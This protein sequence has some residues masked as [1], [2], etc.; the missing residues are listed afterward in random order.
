MTINFF[1][2]YFFDTW[3]STWYMIAIDYW[4]SYWAHNQGY[5][6]VNKMLVVPF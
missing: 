5:T 1:L 2:M 4:N 6:T 3:D